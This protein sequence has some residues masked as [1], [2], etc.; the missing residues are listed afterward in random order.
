[1]QFDALSPVHDL[2]I[3]CAFHWSIAAVTEF[4]IALPSVWTSLAMTI[5]DYF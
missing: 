2:C 4:E 3:P 1:M 5:G